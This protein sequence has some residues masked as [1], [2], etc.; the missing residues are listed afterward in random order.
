MFVICPIESITGICATLANRTPTRQRRRYLA[1]TSRLPARATS[2]SSCANSASCTPTY[3]VG[4]FIRHAFDLWNQFRTPDW[5]TSSWIKATCLG[6][7]ERESLCQKYRR[8]ANNFIR[9]SI[10]YI[11]N[12]IIRCSSQETQTPPR[13]SWTRF[14]SWKWV[15]LLLVAKTKFKT[16]LR[17]LLTNLNRMYPDFHIIIKYYHFLLCFL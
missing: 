3:N 11:R 16:N 14:T 2:N 15:F 10:F 4:F 1:A 7:A 9:C 8:C 12:D 13:A 6:K 5:I 17:L